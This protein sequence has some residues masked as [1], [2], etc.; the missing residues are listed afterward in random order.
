MLLDILRRH[1]PFDEREAAML[2]QI[3]LF[4]EQNERCF[5]RGLQIGH[6]TGSAW[7][8]DFERS[9]TLLT[10]HAKLGKWLQ[11]GGHSDGESNTLAVALREAREETGLT[12]VMPVSPDIF[13]VDTH[14][15]PA[16]GHEP[17]HIHYDVR[18]LFEADTSEPLITSSE[19]AALR[20]VALSEVHTL[21]IDA[22]V[23]RMVAGR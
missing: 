4:V 13:D 16:R 17:E 11:P 5:D 23:L 12:S 9:R 6:I 3:T 8:I 15:I 18:F 14:L 10:H 22:S 20:W 21:N 19:S 7:V 1:R 2:D